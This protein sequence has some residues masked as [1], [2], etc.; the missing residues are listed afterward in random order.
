MAEKPKIMI[1]IIDVRRM[2]MSLR[3]QNIYGN[4]FYGDRSGY[5]RK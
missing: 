5:Q 4:M 1:R 2:L 3:L